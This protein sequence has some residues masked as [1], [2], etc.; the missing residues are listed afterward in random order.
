MRIRSLPQ[1]TPHHKARLLTLAAALLFVLLTAS[2]AFAQT[3][4]TALT[5]AVY[6]SAGLRLPGSTVTIVNTA[7]GKKTSLETKAQG[8]FSFVQILPG[9]YDVT[10]H[11]EG[12]NDNVQSVD[13]YI[14]TP[15]ALNV[16]LAVGTSTSVSVEA[17]LPSTLN[18]VD[19]SLGKP[20]NNQQI[21]TLPYL[22]NNTLSLLALQPGVLSF[23][24]GNT[25]DVRAGTINGAR[26]DQTN[27]TLDGV[28]NNEANFGYAF[29]GVLR[30]TR[31]SIEE[32]RVTTSGANADAGRSSGA[33]VAL[34]TKSGTNEIHG[35]A[36]YYYRDP[37]AASNNWFNKQAQLN[38]GSPNISAKVLQDTYGATLGLPIIK[39]KL[40][41]F[42]A[43]EGFKQASDTVVTQTVPL[44][45][46][47]AADFGVAPGLR[48]GTLT[49]L[50][51]LG[52]HTTLTP[53]Q[54]ASMD[55]GCTAS[56]TCPNGPGVDAATLAY[57]RQYPISNSGNAGDGFNTG[58]YVFTSPSPVSQITNI[59][60]MDYSITPKQSFFVRGNLQSDNVAGTSQFP[61]GIPGSNT[62]GNSRGIA[63]GH[64][65]SIN[66]HVTN[67]ARYGWT[68][69][70]SAIKGGVSSD[71]VLFDA[72]SSYTPTTT[73]GIFI[74]NTHNFA[75]DFSIVKGRHTFQFGGNDRLIYNSRLITANQYR[76]GYVS[77]A[78]L[79]A[80]GIA[81]KGSNLDASVPTTGFPQ[82]A[83]SFNTFYDYGVGA[84]AGLESYATEYLNYSVS[85]N[86][87]TPLPI[88]VLPSHRFENFEQEYYFQ[89]QFRITEKLIV[90]AGLRY[91]YLGVP[92]ETNGQ[93]VRLT[94]SLHD[95]VRTRA[96]DAAIGVSYAPALAYGPGGKANNQPG[97]WTPQKLNFA[98]RLAFNYA[99]DAKTSLRGGFMLA[100]DHFGQ[101]AVD[102]QN[103]DGSFG[104]SSLYTSGLSQT[105]NSSPRFVS[106]TSVPTSI[107][108]VT[109]TG[110]Q[111]FPLTNAGGGNVIS[112][113]IDDKMKT[114]YAEV[115][116][117]SIQ[118]EVHRGLTFTAAYVGRL[119][120]HLI[121]YENAL[122]AVNLTDPASGQTWYQAATI[123]DKA[124]DAGQSIT[125][126]QNIPYLQNI[127]P[128]A[129]Y[130][131]G[132]VTYHGTQAVYGLL[133]RG[134]E[135]VSLY[136]LDSKASNSAGGQSF[137]F[138]SPQ[139]SGIYMNTSNLMSSYNGLQLSLR[140]T[141]TKSFIYDFNYTLAH[142]LDISS[143][144]ERGGSAV[145]ETLLSYA[146][147]DI[148]INP[149]NP[150][151]QY[152]NSDYDV[153]HLISAD[154]TLALPYG[155]GQ[156]FGGKSSRSMNELLG[157]WNLT[158]VAKW[159]SGLPW[160]TISSV[161]WA[162]DEGYRAYD[163][164]IAPVQN[165]GHHTYLKNTTGV[166]TPNAFS[167]GTAAYNSFRLAYAGESGQ[168]NNLRADGY[169]SVD[170]GLS[171]SF[172]TFAG[173]SLKLTVE[174]FNVFNSTR[175]GL[176]AAAN[177]GRSGGTVF[178]TY[179]T[180]LNSPRQMQFSGRYYF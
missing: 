87:L 176:P 11:H 127:F 9:H 126:I 85:G 50:N 98:P 146:N 121:G 102:V 33:Q 138:Y 158:G 79:A 150:Y 118:R 169:F 155:H 19:A 43:Y 51:T 107:L 28:D 75:D 139:F 71:Y 130:T 55:Q 1:A 103:D 172:Q 2:S 30:A 112:Y 108:P 66:D 122:Q 95:L 173:Q 166:I 36:Y 74:E 167:N 116:D 148:V 159:S 179:T 12:F 119:G 149:Y 140:H 96:A 109:P 61:G 4:T 144:P 145:N 49:Y 157:G 58:G 73:S 70:G 44:G 83:T 29:T 154:W 82:I 115:F 24:A 91:S 67:N 69:F 27:L 42:G 37:A 39:N 62:Y 56:G 25:L 113:S 106:A 78:K 123:L 18:Q 165:T 21:S 57:M 13:L 132:G 135:S 125:T 136:S 5:G 142:S 94:T 99:P 110:P 38:S 34:Q 105:V 120:R 45:T 35:T 14:A 128:N 101:A 156:R 143:S 160:S 41:F 65:W 52:T 174:T 168:R 178:G 31:D 129:S 47:N 16:K 77:A 60:R 8:E 64:I 23:D 162:T 134:S 163:V 17:D 20:F 46:G 3:N 32:F 114:P 111:T 22:A 141:L 180:L 76:V 48:N 53:S 175:F 89:D 152:G 26:Q 7:T 131:T 80:G 137:R 151:Q 92:Y 161:G 170:P 88:G 164:Q 59:A 100:F 177:A 84:L 171:K 97:F 6:D 124:K 81:N 104:L 54:I 72:F 90:T 93:Q 117:L 63:V 153:R 86:T 147:S 68:R 40:F 10:I 15:M 133:T